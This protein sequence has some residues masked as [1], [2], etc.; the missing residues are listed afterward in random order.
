MIPKNQD[1][2]DMIR[3]II[4]AFK[5]NMLPEFE[6]GNRAGRRLIVPNT[7]DIQYMYVGKTNE[8]L[9]NISTC[10]LQDMTVQYGGSRYKT[11]D[12]NSEGAPPVETSLSLNFQEMELITRERVFEGF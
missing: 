6:G 9:H 7:F 12:A 1:E 8:Y 2:A 11:F 4:F 3:K 5:A 10:V